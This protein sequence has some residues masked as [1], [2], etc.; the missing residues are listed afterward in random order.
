MT[1]ILLL[2]LCLP[3]SIQRLVWW[4]VYQHPYTLTYFCCI[5]LPSFSILAFPDMCY[6][7]LA[8]VNNAM[9]FEPR[10]AHVPLSFVFFSP[11]FFLVIYCI[12]MFLVLKVEWRHSFKSHGSVIPHFAFKLPTHISIS[13]MV[14][15]TLTLSRSQ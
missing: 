2:I 1:K 12:P 6:S 15:L 3:W 5:A 8:F 4:A 14:E 10:K 13:R 7:F 11:F 9:C